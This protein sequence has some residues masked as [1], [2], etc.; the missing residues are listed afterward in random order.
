MPEIVAARASINKSDYGIK[1]NPL[2]PNVGEKIQLVI[3]V[4]LHDR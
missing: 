2:E 3:D 1:G 4:E